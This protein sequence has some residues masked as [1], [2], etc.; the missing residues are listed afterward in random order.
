M[1]NI[2]IAVIYHSGYGHTARQAKAVKAG[3]ERVDGA[4]GLLLAVEDVPARWNDLRSAEAIIFGTPT[5]VGGQSAAFK[6]FQEASSSAVMAKGYLWKNKFA[7]GFTN[8][9]TAS[10]DKLATLMQLALFA[11]QHGM[12]WINLDLPPANHSTKGS[13][14]DLNRLGFWLGAGAQSYVDQGADLAPP[15]SDLE[16]ASHLGQRVAETTLQFVRGRTVEQEPAL[17]AWRTAGER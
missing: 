6:S 1:S 8:S 11:A 15:P 3:I 2:C 16:T 5:Y 4:Q 17:P 10:G 7:A 13:P 9:G 14:D 12:H